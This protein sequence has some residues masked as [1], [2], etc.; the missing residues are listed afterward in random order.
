MT[1]HAGLRAEIAEVFESLSVFDV[2]SRL[3]WQPAGISDAERE[4]EREYQRRYQRE[5]KRKRDAPKREARAA[6]RAELAAKVLAMRAEGYSLPAIGR[7]IGKAP[8][9]VHWIIKR[10]QME[11]TR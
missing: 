11:A 2:W 9:S 6:R 10:A 1:W 3:G 5:R 8:G 4:R 7:R